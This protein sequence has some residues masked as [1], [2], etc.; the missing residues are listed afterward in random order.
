MKGGYVMLAEEEEEEQRRNCLR[1]VCGSCLC[2][3]HNSVL[4]LT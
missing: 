3:H 2:R 4:K 1:F